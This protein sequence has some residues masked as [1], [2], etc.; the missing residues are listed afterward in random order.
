MNVLLYTKL[1]DTWKKELNELQNKFSK[2][3][4]IIETNPDPGILARTDVIIGGVISEDIIRKAE[5]LR[6][7]IV[8]FA[9][10]DHLPMKL[11]SN[12]NILAANSHGN[13]E[14]VAERAFAMILAFYG[15][16]V[17]YHNDLKKGFWHGF[18]VGKGLDDSWESI[19]GK[20]C[21]II[22]AGRIGCSLAAMLK[23]FEIRVTGYKRKSVNIIP[24]FFDEIVYDLDEALEKSEIIVLSLPSTDSTKEL[25]DS[26][27]LARMS[28]KVIV[29]VGRGELIDQESLY[30]NLKN[31]NLKGAA[32]DCWYNYPKNGETFGF[33]SDL[34]IYDLPNVVLS[35]HVAG[36][37]AS[38]SRK[39]IREAFENLRSFLISNRP[40]S[41]VDL[42]S[43]Y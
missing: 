6:L 28:G 14:V 30:N 33:P 32:I 18:W 26:E 4:F 42:T 16:V 39:N 34:P 22:G 12:R 13:A 43:G 24:D 23:P 17:N 10:V 5:N 37:T 35:P 27:K 21:S 11:M 7:V 15:R 20:T 3:N 36:Y 1:N 29:N 2:V 9:G 31:G 25:F 38:A 41:E 40:V 19:R 8:P